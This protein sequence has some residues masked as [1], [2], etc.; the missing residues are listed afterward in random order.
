[1]RKIY[2]LLIAFICFVKFSIGQYTWNGSFSTFYT[3]A[4]NWTPARSIP[5]ATDILTFPAG[6][7]V[8]DH[9]ANETIAGIV[10][11]AGATVSLEA[12][13]PANVLTINGATP[14]NITAGSSLLA[15][16]FLTIQL[17][18]ATAVNTGTFGILPGSGGKIIINSSLAING[19][20]LNFDVPL[21]STTVNGTGSITYTLG[22]FACVT[23]SAITYSPGATYNHAIN[24]STIPAAT[25]Q[26]GSFCR[27]TGTTNIAPTGLSGIDFAN[28]TW[29][30][31]LQSAAI[32]LILPVLPAIFNI[33]GILSVTS[34]NNQYLRFAGPGSI[35]TGS[36]SQA[37][38]S[39]VMLQ[40]Q[41]GNNTV[42][43]KGAF[44]HLAGVLD[45]VGNG[46]GGTAI[47]D[48]KGSVTKAATWT[49]SSS[50]STALVTIQFSGSLP[51]TVNIISSAWTVSGAGRCN[52]TISNFTGSGVSLTAGSILRV[53][54]NT[55]G[56]AATCTMA[57]Y[58]NAGA[59]ASI[60]YSGS[61]TGGLTLAYNGGFLQTATAIEFPPATTA[62]NP[63]PGPTNLTINNTLGVAFPAGFSRFLTGTL[64]MT[65]GNLAVGVGNTLSLTNSSL[66]TQLSYIAG[67]ITTGTL[68]RNFPAS[69]LPTAQAVEG[70][71]PFG[72]GVN[73][74]SLYVYFSLVN[75]VGSTAGMINVSHNLAT[76]VA[77]ILP[78]ISDNGVNLDKRTNTN[79]TISTSGGFTLGAATAALMAVGANIGAVDD[80]LKLRL[81]DGSTSYGILNPNPNTGSNA[82]PVTGK[83]GL[84]LTD[85]NKP[86]YIGSDGTTFYNPLIIITFTWTG[87]GLNTNWTDQ[88]NW[89]APTTQGYP[90]ASTE[91]ALILTTLTGFQ[92]TINTATNISLFQLR[93]AAGMTL[94]MAGTSSLTVFDDI[95]VFTGS[96]VFDPASTFGYAS[97]NNL[98]TIKTLSAPY[99]N[100]TISGTAGKI[101]PGVVTVTGVYTV[102]GAVPNVTDNL[103]TFIYAG[104]GAQ[105]VTPGVKYYNLTLTGNRGG[106]IVTLGFPN[107]STPVTI[108]IANVFSVSTLS[109]FSY[110][111][112]FPFLSFVTVNFSS[113]LAQTIPGFRYPFAIS[114]ASGHRTFDPLGSANA[115][116]VIACRTMSRGVGVYTI[117]DSKVNLYVSGTVSPT[118]LVWES[119]ND[120]EISGDLNNRVLDFFGGPLYI[121]G[122]FIVSLTNYQQKA[123]AVTYFIF[124]GTGDQTIY[125]FKSTTSSPANTP[126]FKYPNIIILGGNRNVTLGN[127][128]TVK[129]T[130]TL[131][132]P[133]AGVYN[134]TPF[135]LPIDSFSAGKGFIVDGS[136]VNFSVGS[137]MVPV[138]I[139]SSIGTYNY[140]NLMVSGGT[141][142]L[143]STNMTVGNNL[144][145][146]GDVA[147][148]A[149]L[150]IGD[151]ATSR[152]FNV[153]GDVKVSGATGAVITGQ[154][155]LNPGT[156]GSTTMNLSKSLLIDGR[157][158]LTSTGETNG[159]I[160]F[161]GILAHNYTNTSVYKNDFVNFTVGDGITASR[162]T[163]L[164]SLELIGSNTTSTKMGTLSILPTNTLDCGI[165]NV[166]GN[167]IANYAKFDLQTNATLITANTG[168]IEGTATG[169]S[170][171]SIINDATLVRTYSPTASYLFNAAAATNMSFPT[172][173]AAFPMA[174]LT[175][176]N[177]VNAAI[178][179]LNKPIAISDSFKLR[180]AATIALGNFDVTLISTAS[181]TARV[182]Q[183][184]T[185]AVLTYGTGRFNIERY[186]PARRAW[187]LITAPIYEGG[188]V[189]NTWQ[190]SGANT[191]G[192]GTWVTGNPAINGID[193]SP[194]RNS[195]LKEGLS[196]TPVSN[197]IATL[198]S[199]NTGGVAD[200][201]VFFLYVRGDRNPSNFNTSISNTTTL[202][203]RGKIQTGTQTFNA[204]ATAGGYTMIGNPYASPVDFFK[205][206]R[207]NIKDR[208]WVWD[209][210]LGGTAGQGAYIPFVGDG[211]GNYT[212]T[213]SSPSGFS[214]LFQS[215]Q[216][217]IVETLNNGVASLVFEE[218]NKSLVNNSTSFFRP[219]KRTSFRVI[220]NQRERDSAY[221]T[222]GVL[223]Q[224]GENFNNEVDGDDMIKIANTN[225]ML[226]IQKANS[227]LAIER[228]SQFSVND[229]IYLKLT[230]TKQR[231]YSFE[232]VPENLSPTLTAFVDDSYTNI[233]TALSVTGS[234]SFDF[235]VNADAKS[236]AA[237]RFKIVFKQTGFNTLPVTFKNIKAYGQGAA[238]NVDWTVENEINIS[239]YEVEKSMNGVDFVKVNTTIATGINN[240][241]TTYN[242]LDITPVQGN[243][244]Y[245]IRSYNQSGSFDY[246]KIVMVK[247]G[248]T[249]TGIS[250][251]PNPVK[252]NQ[253]GVEFSNM[254]K[255]V[256]QIR[257]INSLGQTM[258]ARQFINSGGSSMVTFTPESNLRAGIYQ[259]EIIAQDNHHHTIKVIV[260]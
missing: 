191:P 225:E 218:N 229:T 219:A 198:I 2:F 151:A 167:G 42:T 174:N 43:V 169:S 77:V 165:F 185:S 246:S 87:N 107:N 258:L 220:L 211:F 183:L 108:E 157:G 84:T 25:W 98:Q 256:Y 3:D 177:N 240:S 57:G 190:I 175:L 38:S 22:S 105:Y 159:N 52:I 1:M 65:A 74:R 30:C 7:F 224:F 129:I 70:R 162:L 179:T 4:T 135:S 40:S 196:Y 123:N 117:A 187:R 83:S 53:I 118:Y 81:T 140:H 241:S 202:T 132:V 237:N 204:S 171:G 182:S 255:G 145:D 8:V 208:F 130:G 134:S 101:L 131:Q 79:W 147:S 168:G 95:P 51:Q 173:P 14:L 31:L 186:Y 124:N 139:P 71:F 247:L 150:K 67:Y 9:V 238:I 239:K 104:T 13:N 80:Y 91:I 136:T 155:D 111:P 223:I 44:S 149:V 199:N 234:C 103:N 158:Q 10:V 20:T 209:P 156:L 115:A 163:L 94:T 45:G 137:G 50:S 250:V 164:N 249:G 27:I 142:I 113:T 119:Y 236:A 180:N 172:T 226:G 122:K 11:Q 206:T 109:N 166:R 178:F 66:S 254:E 235:V 82:A 93:V 16:T 233:Q 133:R 19:G 72:A 170:T 146:S 32:D 47:L 189:Y 154:I 125:G 232:F 35:S 205:A 192:R 201:K 188:S 89:S 39:N 18:S 46:S 86:I 41:S 55:N 217:F 221:V 33:G 259:L 24:G 161:K 12:D 92:P 85:L 138:L 212:P 96:F 128:D 214:N 126:A 213:I 56:S 120:L 260:Q 23:P 144:T 78:T 231:N 160:I 197:T 68:S 58:V 112:M 184:G 141:R 121:A 75:P 222:D 26:T 60:I 152:I 203:G 127:T 17:N 21:G 88:N 181:K 29:N 61:G 207:N 36:Y 34:T 62:P 49:C 227:S 245:R 195:S 73:D 253:I 257:L 6:S 153:L 69:G 244:F 76:T 252:D 193:P 100:L 242:F 63:S 143:E 148:P 194:Q 228:R 48:L 243:N 54:N 59:G 64:N 230:K 116:N 248:K 97:S 210:Q 216:A 251:Y 99:A 15:S 5:L 215:S 37:G 106:G 102:T 28:F 110:P 176:G 200:N 90:S 114:N